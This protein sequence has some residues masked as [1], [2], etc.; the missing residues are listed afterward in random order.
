METKLYTA[1]QLLSEAARLIESW[2]IGVVSRAVS[3][4]DLYT[5]VNTL[6]HLASFPTVESK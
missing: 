5:T 3:A 2:P 4:S 1:Q 6:K